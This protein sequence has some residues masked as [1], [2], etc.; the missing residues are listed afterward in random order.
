MICSNAV[1]D[2][3]FLDPPLGAPP[4]HRTEI[5]RKSEEK[6]NFKDTV[7]TFQCNGLV[8]TGCMKT[9]NFMFPNNHQNDILIDSR[10][11]F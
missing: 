7:V 5:K 9:Y 3:K 4:L 2:Q 11:A 8:S 1:Q 6:V 10:E